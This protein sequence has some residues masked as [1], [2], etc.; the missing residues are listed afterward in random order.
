MVLSGPLLFGPHLEVLPVVQYN[1]YTYL[2][3]VM[4]TRLMN[5]TELDET[6]L[7]ISVEFY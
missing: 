6:L 7:N 1:G 3:P 4:L 5:L 2:K